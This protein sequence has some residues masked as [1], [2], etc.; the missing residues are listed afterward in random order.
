M[1][2]VLFIAPTTREHV[3]LPKIADELGIKL[4]WDDFV[5]DYFDDFLEKD[6][7]KE[8]TLDIVALIEQTIEKYKNQKL[9]GVISAVGYPGMSAVAV[10]AERLGLPGP[11]PKAIMRCEHKYYSRL[12]QREIVPEATPAFHLIDPRDKSTLENVKDLPVFLKPVKSSMSM[13]AFQIHSREELIERAAIAGMPERFTKP[14]DDMTKAYTDLDLSCDYLIVEDLLKGR[15]VSLEGFV[16]G[17]KPVIMG[18]VDGE[19][20]PD[21]L[22]FNRWLYPSRLPPHVLDQ[23]E[24]IATRFFKGIEYDS[25][26]FNMELIWDEEAD[27]VFIIEVNPKIASQFPDLFE[28]VDGTSSYKAMLEIA[29]G[30]A[31]T[32]TRRKGEFKVA[33]SCVLRSFE[34]KKVVRK[35]TKEDVAAV[36]KKYPD[37]LVSIIATEGKNLSEQTQD[38]FTYRYG[39]INIGAQSVEELEGKNEDCKSL[40][41]FE[42]ASA[43]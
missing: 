39:L 34:D 2:N 19:M 6:A 41:N 27:H 16:Y 12:A 1:K 18:I 5:G 3:A 36:R 28:K 29:V 32:F 4:I 15:Q 9:S 25:A 43:K 26:M 10:I 13:N 33:A 24:S 11:K 22:S 8:N 35:P 30:T 31:P 42:F 7:K 17:G 21:T 20:V 38:T 37:A 40:L 23:M 14:F